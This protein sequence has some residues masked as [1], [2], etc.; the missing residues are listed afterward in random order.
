MMHLTAIR[1]ARTLIIAA[2]V[3]LS[4][5]ALAL[6]A[7]RLRGQL[8]Q[9]RLD[10]LTHLPTRAVLEDTGPRMT[11]AHGDTLAVLIDA[12]GFKLLN[13]AHG[14]AAGDTV[15][16]AI[17]DRL[18]TWCVDHHGLAVR[19]GGDE[20]AAAVRLEAADI[21][22]ALNDLQVVLTRPV[23][24]DGQ[25][26]V[27]GAS[28][29]AATTSAPGRTWPEA[30]RAADAAMYA[31]KRSGLQLPG[32]ATT[33]DDAA[34]S[35]N[36]RR[37]GR[38]GAQTELPRRTVRL[39][40]LIGPEHTAEFV[41]AKVADMLNE[42][43]IPTAAARRLVAD[44]IAAGS[45]HILATTGQVWALRPGVDPGNCMA[46]LLYIVSRSGN[47][48]AVQDGSGTGEELIVSIELL[49]E[50]YELDC[51]SWAQ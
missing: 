47:S 16:R 49:D 32:L 30:L 14:H 7:R 41:A 43:L 51:W 19:L 31:A 18:Q 33:E 38:P 1:Q 21:D 40:L 10:P 48:V 23:R 20:F 50:Q 11:A 45:P 37:Y 12:D 9:A 42:D 8:R 29:G 2:A 36:G 39:D 15:L 28:I 24:H 4:L 27:F 26:M 44:A 22:D 34:A 25:T 46:P 35:V 6:D 3:P 13:D 17:A 5:A